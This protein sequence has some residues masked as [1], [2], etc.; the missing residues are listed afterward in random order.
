MNILEN[1]VKYSGENCT[2]DCDVK[3]NSELV[4]AIKDNGIGISN[5]DKNQVFE[6]FF[7]AGDKEIHNVK[8]LGLGLYYTNQIIKAHNGNIS[9][10]SKED[11]G[12][13]FTLT[14]PFN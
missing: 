4:I 9:V 11:K 12:T 14:I 2:I 6:K 5:K 3:S 13:T 10:E 1:A 8:G 7:R